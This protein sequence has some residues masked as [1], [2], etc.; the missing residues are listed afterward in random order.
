MRALLGAIA[1]ALLLAGP[2]QAQWDGLLQIDDPAGVFLE[3]QVAA[4]RVPSI[5]LDTQP[6]SAAEALRILDSL[7]AGANGMSA[8]DRRLLARFRRAAPSPGSTRLRALAPFLYGNGHDAVATRGDGFGV[9]ANPVLVARAGRARLRDG[10]A[11]ETRTAWAWER[12]ARV[13][14]HVG[15]HLYFVSQMTEYLRRDAWP[16]PGGGYLPRRGSASLEDPPDRF[17]YGGF[18]AEATVG[19]HAGPFEA[20]FT[21]GRNRWAW[22]HG[23]LILSPF[24]APYDQLQ[25]GVRLGAV[26]F[27][28]LV[29]GLAEPRA[30]PPTSHVAVPRKT[31]SL[32]RISVALPGRLVIAL[33]EATVDFPRTIGARDS[34]WPAI[35]PLPFFRTLGVVDAGERFSIAGAGAAWVPVP[36]YRTYGELAVRRPLPVAASVRSRAGILVG[37]EVADAVLPGLFLRVEATRTAEALYAEG[38]SFSSFTHLNDALGHPA[39]GGARDVAVFVR[40]QPLPDVHVLANFAYTRWSGANV[41]APELLLAEASAAYEWLPGLLLEASLRAESPPTDRRQAGLVPALGL[42]WNQP[43]ESRRY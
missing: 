39:G 9:Q 28:H 37:V 18:Q 19:L 41:V 23:S 5:L 21:R 20:R 14:G 3:R 38:G 16:M 12:G 34:A 43:F 22:G 25:W 32:F 35:M 17:L 2:V 4:G 40:Y 29:A 11:S 7:M 33:S 13:S 31:A 27:L 1:C 36:G 15:S 42:R 8:T 24:A 30:R 26:R 6:L 10:S